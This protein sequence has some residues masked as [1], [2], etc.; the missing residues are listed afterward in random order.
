MLAV[1]YLYGHPVCAAVRLANIDI[2]INE[3]L[4][5]NALQVG[6]DQIGSSLE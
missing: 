5:E 3:K 6:K 4:P 2:I 1:T